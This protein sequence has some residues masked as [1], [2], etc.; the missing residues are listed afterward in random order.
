M[1]KQQGTLSRRERQI[2]DI[3]FRM[4][5][6]TAAQVMGEMKDP[7]GYSAVR[8]LLATL[9]RKG[10]IRHGKDGAK[11]VFFPVQQTHHASRSALAHLIQTFFDGSRARAAAALL[12]IAPQQFSEEELDELEGLIQKARKG[13]RGEL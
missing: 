6:A 9:E 11:F 8:T 5:R 4:K 2:M 3:L 12:N 10:H 13:D 7:P 1:P